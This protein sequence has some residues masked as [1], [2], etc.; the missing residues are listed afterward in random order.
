MVRFLA[1]IV[2]GPMTFVVL[3]PFVFY[4]TGVLMAGLAR[5]QNPWAGLC[6][7]RPLS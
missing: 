2:S 1:G 5:Q 7:W 6:S 4:P 3:W